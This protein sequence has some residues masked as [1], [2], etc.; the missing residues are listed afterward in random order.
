LSFE[1]TQESNGYIPNGTTATCMPCARMREAH[2]PGNRVLQVAQ[3]ALFVCHS[4]GPHWL[5]RIVALNLTSTSVA[6]TSQ[7][8]QKILISPSFRLA[9]A[10]SHVQKSMVSSIQDFVVI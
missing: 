4:H 7:P 6:L 9:R 1:N 8:L 10:S 2:K 3:Q 5:L